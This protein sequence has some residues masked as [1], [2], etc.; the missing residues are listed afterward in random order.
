MRSRFRPV[1]MQLAE[2]L[3]YS[4]VQAKGT[5]PTGRATCLVGRSQLGEWHLDGPT[6][7]DWTGGRWVSCKQHTVNWFQFVLGLQVR[8][9]T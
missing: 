7:L 8:A 4:A 9:W 1:T 6:G 5:F 3:Y 2:G